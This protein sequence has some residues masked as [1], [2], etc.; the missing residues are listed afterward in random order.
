MSVLKNLINEMASAGAVSAG[1]IGGFRGSLFGGKPVSRTVSKKKKAKKLSEE[2]SSKSFGDEKYDLI[3]TPKKR[4]SK[5]HD[6]VV[7]KKKLNKPVRKSTFIDSLRED[8]EVTDRDLTPSEKQ[9][10]PDDVISKLKASE[11][12]SKLDKDTVAFGMEDEDGSIVKV[13]VRADQAKDFEQA[14]QHALAQEDEDENEKN[15]S[16]EIAAVL[17][18]MRKKFDIVDVEWPEVQEDE[19]EDMTVGGEDAAAA[20]DM[21]A[22]DQLPT[23]EPPVDTSEEKAASALDAVIDM[24]K[25]DAEA[26]A[27]EAQARTKE[28]EAKIADTTARQ[29]EAKV[30]QEEEVLDMEA[31]YD[32]KGEKEKEAKRLAKLAK[33]KH[34]IKKDEGTAVKTTGTPSTEPAPSAELTTKELTVTPPEVGAEEE[35]VTMIP[36][37]TIPKKVSTEELVKLIRKSVAGN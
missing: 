11:R 25:K 3:F 4:E 17:F 18:N 19:E 20:E 35:E 14:I 27:A 28:A 5:S 8:A 9:F 32:N 6:E 26:R 12:K 22:T 23:E 24:M 15:S 34:D 21:A 16:S 7:R 33:W 1:D 36:R 29:A 31:Y 37:V 13:Y 2:Q 30:K 10:N